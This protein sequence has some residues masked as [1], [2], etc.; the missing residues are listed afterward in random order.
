MTLERPVICCRTRVFGE[1]EDQ[2]GRTRH[3]LPTAN[4]PVRPDAIT[5]ELNLW[6]LEPGSAS[7]RSKQQRRRDHEPERLHRG[8]VFVDAAAAIGQT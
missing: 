4:L 5:C 1:A 3:V 2:T 8:I 6:R 7:Q